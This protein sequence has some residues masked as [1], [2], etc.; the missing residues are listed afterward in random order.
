MK[1]ILSNVL[2]IA[3][4]AYVAVNLFSCGSGASIEPISTGTGGVCSIE[5][6]TS[7]DGYA[8][9]YS[10]NSEQKI[11]KVNLTGS[12]VSTTFTLSYDKTQ[13]NGPVVSIGNPGNTS[14]TVLTYSKDN[15]LQNAT[16]T[17]SKKDA[18]IILGKPATITNFKNVLTF[19]WNSNKQLVTQTSYTTSIVTVNGVSEP[20]DYD[21]YLSYEYETNGELL[22][23]NTYTLELLIVGG[24][25][26]LTPGELLSFS[27]FEYETAI[28]EVIQKTGSTGLIM[29][30]S[31]D[32]QVV[33]TPKTKNAVKKLTSF[34][35]DANGG[36]EQIVTNYTNT[37]S[38]SGFL[39]KAVGVDK[40]GTETITY[41]YNSCK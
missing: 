16:T 6:I 23:I 39:S 34:L 18:G 40:F 36:F 27:L 11:D 24:K 4:C 1:K 9:G 30:F 22:R 20:F 28:P 14:L 21:G 15:L 26:V 29:D 19:V 38:A 5:S 33:F 7:S 32:G 41:S 10:Y 25:P 37:K 31:D 13:T 2:S 12:G 35:P 17:I 3:I 8:I